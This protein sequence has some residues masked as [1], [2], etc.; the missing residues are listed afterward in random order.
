MPTVISVSTWLPVPSMLSACYC[1]ERHCVLKSLVTSGYNRTI[2]SAS[3]TYAYTY[4][5]A[6][7]DN[8]NR[9]RGAHSQFQGECPGFR[10]YW[11]AVKKFGNKTTRIVRQRRRGR[12]TRMKFGCI[13]KR[14][15]RLPVMSSGDILSK[16]LRSQ[17]PID[18]R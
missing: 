7:R 11:P 18:G 9:R 3:T 2:S 16:A 14:R 15:T 8:T 17:P 5:S 12:E 4:L 1:L 6:A 13:G 10:S